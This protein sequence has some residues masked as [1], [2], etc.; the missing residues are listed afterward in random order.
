[1]LRANPAIV[2]T[3]SLEEMEQEAAQEAKKPFDKMVAVSIALTAAVLAVVGAFA[4]HFAQE[5][6]LLQAKASDTWSYYQAKSIRRYES[7]VARD[8]FANQPGD[9]SAELSRNYKEKAEGYRHDG[10]ELTKRANGLEDESRLNGRKA[11]RLH[12]AEI[13]LEAGMALGSI[14]ILSRMG[15][16]WGIS[17]ASAIAGAVIAATAWTIVPEPEKEKA[18]GS[19]YMISQPALEAAPPWWNSLPESDARG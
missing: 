4:Q 15:L 5:E 19:A 12:I 6:L 3:M 13:F 8:N 14:A 10:D 1:M 18:P 7:E 17:L 2:E 16:I 9:K 11:F